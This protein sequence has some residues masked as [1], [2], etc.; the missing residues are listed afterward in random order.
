M[1][2][3]LEANGKVE[4]EHSLIVKALAKACDG[5]MGAWPRLLPYTL[6]ADSTKHST[7]TR[8][9]S[10]ELILG[11]KPI[12]PIKQSVTSWTALPWQVEMS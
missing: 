4:R 2:Y 9:M 5:K 1:A 6:W 12:M 3:N 11:Q 8:Y 7:T 10:V